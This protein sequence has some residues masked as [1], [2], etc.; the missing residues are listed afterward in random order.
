MSGRWQILC[1]G[2]SSAPST[3]SPSGVRRRRH[4]SYV[5]LTP[6]EDT[7]D[8]N[9]SDGELDEAGP[10]KKAR[11]GPELF[12]FKCSGCKK[13]FKHIVKHLNAI[14]KDTSKCK[15]NR[16]RICGAPRMASAAATASS[17]WFILLY[18]TPSLSLAISLLLL[19][20]ATPSL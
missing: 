5:L 9:G 8:D 3:I 6:S 11:V 15:Q 18:A 16:F 19:S 17:A 2:T 4:S 12:Q 10:S 20:L 13:E 7:A 14:K 1:L